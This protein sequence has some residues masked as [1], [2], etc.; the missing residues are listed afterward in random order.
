MELLNIKDLSIRHKEQ[1]LF[2]K[3]N[4]KIQS[5]TKL[6]IYAPTGCGK[7][8]LLNLIS[9]CIAENSNL[10]I[11]GIIQKKDNLQISYVFQDLRLLE[12][13]SVFDNVFIPLKNCYKKE[14]AKT[15]TQKILQSV[16][17][18]DKINQKVSN[19]SGGEK[20]RVAIARALSFPFDLLL[21]DEAFHA[22]DENK[23]QE[24]LSL[25]KKIVDQSKKALIMVSHNKSE[26]ESL[27][28]QIIDESMFYL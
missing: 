13:I 5:N 7:S 8:T 15:K 10:S 19:L 25:T 23:K 11:S 9:G 12:N 1:I 17:L 22:Q 2:N 18:S 16:F 3:F 6:G 21:L 28:E 20:Q 27:C 14:I 26:L 4:L 24:L